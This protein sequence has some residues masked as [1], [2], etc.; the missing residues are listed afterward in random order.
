MKEKSPISLNTD[1]KHVPT[2][3]FV[4]AP[5]LESILATRLHIIIK[6]LEKIGKYKIPFENIGPLKSMGIKIWEIAKTR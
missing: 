3:L 4:R 2:K 1:S 5:K 6:Q